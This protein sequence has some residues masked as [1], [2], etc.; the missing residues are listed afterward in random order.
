MSR[1]Y[2]TDAIGTSANPRWRTPCAVCGGGM[3][4]YRSKVTGQLFT[5]ACDRCGGVEA[6]A[7]VTCEEHEGDE[8]IYD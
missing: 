8:V 5:H 4:G 1:R 6:L 3:S 2:W 7:E